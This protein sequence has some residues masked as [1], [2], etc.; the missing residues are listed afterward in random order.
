[1]DEVSA[2]QL[3]VQLY[4]IA[5]LNKASHSYGVSLAMWHHT[6]LSVTRH[7]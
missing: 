7:K 5:P 2:K 1:M 6:V 3:N 4:D